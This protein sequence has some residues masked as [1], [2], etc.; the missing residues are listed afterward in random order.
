MCIT[1]RKNI[2]NKSNNV[3]HGKRLY[4]QMALEVAVRNPERYIDF[5]ITLNKF[6]GKIL[7]D[8]CILDIYVQ[9]YIDRV[10]TANGLSDSNL[11]SSYLKNYIISNNKHNNEWGFPTGYQAAFTRYIKTLSEFGFIYAQYN[12]E[13]MI[14]PVGKAII[15]NRITLSEGFALQSMRFWRKSPYR[16]VLNDFNYFEFIIDVLLELNSR[17]KKLSYV[18]F[19]VSL[20]TDNGDVKEFLKE[21]DNNKFGSDL[22]K[23]YKYVYNKYNQIDDDHAKVSKLETSF[24]DYGNTVFR[25]LQL[26]GFI[27]VEY[28]GV[29]L[30]TINNNRVDLYKKLKKEQLK[31][32]ETAKEDELFYFQEVGSLT[33]TL[34][35]L[36]V[37]F[38]EKENLSTSEYNKKIPNI[39]DS[40]N[41]TKEDLK[42][43]LVDVV[44]EK[45]DGR[46]FWFI[47]APVKFELLLTLFL[48]TCYGDAFEYKPNFKCDDAGIPYSHAPG[49]IGDIEIS[50]SY[51]YWLIE[52]TLIR[53][54]FQQINNET[55]GL[56]RHL[57]DCTK[58][59]YM[60]LVAP[61]IHEDT[62]LI[63]NVGTVISSIE[64]KK[65]IYSKAEDIE[66]FIDYGEQET[67]LK[68]TK[69]YTLGFLN[70]LKT[71]INSISI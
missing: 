70:D 11:N 32:S 45:R 36:L 22:D 62:K 12:K 61:Y 60:N 8:K 44:N 16:R 50:N 18:Q 30:L 41:L 1:I 38:R 28:S 14:S 9:L 21:L 46:A 27:T 69:K 40:Y 58:E 54:K 17:G 64:K 33:S 4:K 24:R 20:F 6:D 31:L 66:T 63:I 55:I 34:E 51:V 3:V 48:Y 49:N 2:N 13:L 47:Q 7:D 35:N 37:S 56:F 10:I 43:Y 19:L 42:N 57:A 15:S 68:E 65:L 53:N 5:L 52:A 59:T 71:I 23:A 39:L 25:V 67:N 26:T 29:M